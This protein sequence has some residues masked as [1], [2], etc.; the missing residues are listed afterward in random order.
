MELAAKI[1]NNV[2]ENIEKEKLRKKIKEGGEMSNKR[3][4]VSTAALALDLMFL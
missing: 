1:E 2:G 4:S 3:G